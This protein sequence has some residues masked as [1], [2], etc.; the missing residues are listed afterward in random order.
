MTN[1]G[2]PTSGSP[3]WPFRVRP[4]LVIADATP[5]WPQWVE[6][7]PTPEASMVDIG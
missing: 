6:L 5:E 2:F 1:I 7:R 4:I 3:K